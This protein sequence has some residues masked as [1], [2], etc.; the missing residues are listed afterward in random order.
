MHGPDLTTAVQ[1][2]IRVEIQLTR[3]CYS[4]TSPTK[5]WIHLALYPGLLD[6]LHVV[7]VIHV[8]SRTNAFLS[9]FF[10][11]VSTASDKCSGEPNDQGES[12]GDIIN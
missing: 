11:C 8:S 3:I 7:F 1:P 12:L 4:L 2:T 5:N 6:Q 10:S 9:D